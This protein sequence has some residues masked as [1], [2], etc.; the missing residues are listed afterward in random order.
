MKFRA[1]PTPSED[2]L[3]QCYNRAVRASFKWVYLLGHT[4]C[5]NS[6]SALLNE[7]VLH[8]CVINT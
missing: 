4:K 5:D 7:D 2:M 1:T 3:L 8:Q 6:Q